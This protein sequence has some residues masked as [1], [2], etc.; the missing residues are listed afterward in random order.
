MSTHHLT[1]Q[2]VQRL[3]AVAAL[4]AVVAVLSIAGCDGSNGA[5][6][7]DATSGSGTPAQSN[8]VT[9]S[10]QTSASGALST[11]NQSSDIGAGDTAASGPPAI[12]FE[13][14][15]HDFGDMSETET[16]DTTFKFTNTGGS[17]LTIS[18][19]KP[20]CTCTTVSLAKNSYR[21]GESGE[22]AVRFA[23]TSAGRQKRLIHVASNDIGRPRVTIAVD[24]NVEAF[25]TLEP[26]NLK[27]GTVLPG[28]SKSAYVSVLSPDASMRVQ[29]VSAT[30]PS[31]NVR[32]VQASSAEA[33]APL[34]GMPGQAL[35]E[36]TI[37]EDAPWG[38]L[39]SWV[40]VAVEGTPPDQQQ[41]VVHTRQFRVEASVFGD[42]MADPDAFRAG[43]RPGESFTRSV[44]LKRLSGQPFRIVEAIIDEQT[45]ATLPRTTLQLNR[46][47]DSEYELVLN[48]AAGQEIG[49]FSAVVNIQTD[50]PGEEFIQLDISGRVIGP[51]G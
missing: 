4:I 36:V 15:S 43:A 25:I 6:N 39:F 48:A 33:T 46:L 40:S 18:E 27:L 23:P 47:S 38:P 16:V 14:I 31:V 13:K 28:H 8:A 42:L 19:I 29:R 41:R 10:E 50:V 44:R 37:K 51:A 35:I 3:T 11:D 30:D 7:G 34:V 1:T 21:S 9:P 5:S 32:I 12:T 22:I 24:A 49:N 26:A 2:F 20:T 17:T 45:T